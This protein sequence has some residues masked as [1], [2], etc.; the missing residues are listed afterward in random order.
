MNNLI[1]LLNLYGFFLL[2]FFIVIN[3]LNFR[4]N[5]LWHLIFFLFWTTIFPSILLERFANDFY[6]FAFQWEFQHMLGAFTTLFILSLALIL[7][8]TW[9]RTLFRIW[10]WIRRR[11]RGKAGIRTWIRI[12]RLLTWTLT[13]TRIWFWTAVT[14]TF[15]LLLPNFFHLLLFFLRIL[16]NRTR[17]RRKID[18][19]LTV[20]TLLFTIWTLFIHTLLFMW[21]FCVSIV[22]FS[23][24]KLSLIFFYLSLRVLIMLLS[25]TVKKWMPNC[26][27]HCNSVLRDKA[28]HFRK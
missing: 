4:N 14:G 7:F 24:V 6:I 20:W 16:R 8:T 25:D 18:R 3:F 5:F 17:I 15:L 11:T 21:V 10:T 23:S 9:T 28:Q 22:A 2:F 27:L 12:I 26:I 13:R 19:T 1:L